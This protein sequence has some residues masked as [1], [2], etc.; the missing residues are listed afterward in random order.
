V[1]SN[2]IGICCP[3]SVICGENGKCPAAA[4][5]NAGFTIGDSGEV[6]TYVQGGREHI[7]DY[8]EETGDGAGDTS[9]EPPAASASSDWT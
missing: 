7:M 3:S 8:N 4:V 6:E 5:A 9:S 1:C 2:D